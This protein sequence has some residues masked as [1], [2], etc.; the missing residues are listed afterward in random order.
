MEKPGQPCGLRLTDWPM[1][2][3]IANT[4]FLN[5]LF[6]RS[7]E[8]VLVL[9]ADLEIT[10]A[11]PVATSLLGEQ[12]VPVIGR[13]ITSYL[14]NGFSRNALNRG[15]FTSI[16]IKGCIKSVELEIE[17][18]PSREGNSWVLLI[19][20]RARSADLDS[21]GLWKAEKIKTNALLEAIPDTIFIQDFHGNFLDYYPSISKGLLP[22]ETKIKGRNMAEI[23]PSPVQDL[24]R[25]AIRKIR[26]EGKAQYLEFHLDDKDPKHYEARIVPMNAHMVLTIVRDVSERVAD[27]KALEHEQDRLR[28]YLDSAASLFVVLNP[29]FRIALV[30]EK[31]CK[32]LGYAREDLVGQ[33]WLSFLGESEERKKLQVLFRRTIKGS[34]TLSAYFESYLS[35]AKGQKRLIRWRNALLKDSAGKNVGLVCSGV[36]ISDQK[37]VE[38]KLRKSEST[39]KAILEA[40]P[41]VILLHDKAG[42]ILGVQ[43]A[44]TTTD[45]FKA[46]RIT[47]GLVT[48]VFPEEI[49]TEMLRKIQDSC[50]T[51]EAK[52]LEISTMTAVGRQAF[53]LR[54]VCMDPNRVLAVARD[55]TRAKSTQQVLDL[56]NRALE[57]AGNGILIA[58]ARLPDLPVIYCNEAFT[59]ITQY[60]RDEVLGRNCRFLQ[61]AKTD[62]EKVAIIR[63]ALK[64][65]QGSRVVLRNYRKDGS[66]FWNELTITP[67]TD[68]HET[69]THFIGVQN[70]ISDLIFEGERKDHTRK[71]L[72]A[73]SQ[74][75]PL[76]EISASIVRFL[77]QQLPHLWIQLALW[78]SEKQVLES[79][80]N[81][82]MPET[83]QLKLERINITDESQCPCAEAVKTREASFIEDIS[84]ELV[85]GDFLKAMVKEGIQSCWSYPILSSEK[86]VLGTCTFFSQKAGIPKNGILDLLQDAMQLTGL[87][88]ERHQTR[89]RLEETNRQLQ[90]Q[91]RNLEKDV[92]AR[93]LEV[94]STLQKLLQSNRSLQQQI[95]TTQ[96]AE[97]RALANQALFGAIAKNFPKGVIMVFDKDCQFVHLEGEELDRMGLSRWD[98]FHQH[99]L[100]IP[101]MIMG[102][103]KDLESRIKETLQGQHLS[104]ELQHRDHTY[105]VNSTP[106]QVSEASGWALLVLSNVTEQKKAEEDLLRALRIEQEINDLKSRFISMASHEFRTPLSA[107]HSSAILIGKQN[108]PGK[109]Q[110]RLRYLKQIKNNVRNLVVILDDF[111]SLSKLEEGKIRCHP[112]RFDALDLIRNVLEELESNLKV[113]QHFTE[114]FETATLKVI[115]DP[116]LMRNALVNLLS[117]AIKYSPENSAILI[118]IRTQGDW[119][120]I[121]I[122]D[123][124][125]GIP[126]EE[127]EQLFSRFFRAR[128]ALNIP[129]TGLG[130]HIVKHYLELMGGDISFS[131]DL[132][133]GSTFR[134]RLP[135][136]LNP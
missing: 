28:H 88:I 104:F 63:N 74:D 95:Q 53:E 49:G 25:E 70:D 6:E 42:R 47:G 39:K 52:E 110:N 115:L 86:T 72:E 103:R 27:K 55:I 85:S 50:A 112:E 35:T 62:P 121:A 36:D 129:G 58:D 76:E 87:A 122:K 61:G 133:K 111:L 15:R 136:T 116:K 130:L 54:Y 60:Q 26:Q 100:Q 77:G 109:E 94:E 73:I 20:P 17:S 117:N 10:A 59:K 24:F 23:L 4:E 65:G 66:L 18:Y 93:T 79:L 82:Q 32:T 7:R 106:L 51:G 90:A 80:A 119:L 81:F 107:I 31:V 29:D 45:F 41:D 123:E 68:Q 38:D 126:K 118:H 132:N 5:I 2:S 3:I 22:K 84:S 44:N 13:S 127:Q 102:R 56:R 16:G 71:I 124:G 33:N 98:F 9:N 69:V 40:I 64:N 105:A 120:E 34:S 57:T 21:L 11:N 46:D 67:I 37:A 30:N 83:L 89:Y 48:E 101:G 131:S 113:G 125:I 91:A 97:E 43:D 108:E 78:S 8:A 114:D 135:R 128:N 96:R 1:S 134:L 92:A 12:E 75:H 19:K 14:D 99:I